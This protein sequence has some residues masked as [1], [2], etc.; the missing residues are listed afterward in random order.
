M[1]PANPYHL[2]EG[3]WLPWLSVHTLNHI[4]ASLDVAAAIENNSM[5]ACDVLLVDPKREHWSWDDILLAATHLQQGTLWI[6]ATQ[7]DFT[8]I[9]TAHSFYIP[10]VVLYRQWFD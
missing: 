7:I 8:N 1:T 4:D 9:S 10:F 2:E 5:A 3:S 6:A